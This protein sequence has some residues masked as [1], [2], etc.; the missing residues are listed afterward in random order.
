RHLERG[1]VSITT[2]WLSP[3]PRSALVQLNLD[4]A[5]EIVGALRELK[6]ALSLPGEIDLAFVARQPDVVAM[7]EGQAAAPAWIEVEPIMT[8]A[9]QALNAMRQR[10]G[11]ALATELGRRLDLLATHLLVVEQRAPDRLTAERDRLRRTIDELLEGRTLD[12]ARLAQ[13]VALF[14]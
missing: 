5:R 1:H 12:D 7:T 6:T 9:L 2:R 11:S 10:E 4:R 14:A 3:P 13:E 8:A